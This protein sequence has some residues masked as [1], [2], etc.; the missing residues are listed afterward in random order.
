[1]TETEP[2][3][4][5]KLARTICLREA[6]RVFGAGPDA[7]DAAQDA[8]MRVWRA[9]HSCASEHP[10][11]WMTVIARNAARSRRTGVA[12]RTARERM[13]RDGREPADPRADDEIAS[14]P[15]RLTVQ[16]AL[17]RLPPAD[18]KL[19]RLRYEDDLTQIEI[20]GR[21]GW[22]EGTVKVRL[23]RLRRHLA[24]ELTPT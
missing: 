18:R 17:S 15:E 13:G 1:M 16:D 6:C 21:L 12:V 19:L 20:A 11:A 5:W 24:L 2:T 23:H 10:E 8:L 14:A 9:R 7:E 3:W 22:P 4:G